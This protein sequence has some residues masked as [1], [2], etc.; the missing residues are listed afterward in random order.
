M[1]SWV[2]LY[3]SI[4]LLA[5]HFITPANA[6]TSNSGSHQQEILDGLAF[7]RNVDSLI[8]QALAHR[9]LKRGGTVLS[10]RSNAAAEFSR[11][12]DALLFEL[13]RHTSVNKIEQSDFYVALNRYISFKASY[14][15]LKER[16]R[17]AR[18]TLQDSG[19]S[20]LII[21]RM[22]EE[23]VMLSAR[24]ERVLFALKDTLGALE[25]T[26]KPNELIE[27][28]S[29]RAACG[30]AFGEANRL[31]SAFMPA[32]KVRILGN[33]QLSL[34]R[35]TY[36]TRA[37]ILTPNI[38]PSYLS[39]DEQLQTPESVDF[40]A[41]VDAPLSEE[42]LALARS[43]NYDYIRIYEYV[44]NNIRTEWYAG[45]MKGAVGALRQKS[46]NDVDQASLLIA[47][48]RA[49]GVTARYIHG[50]VELPIDRLQASLGVSDANQAIRAVTLAGIA[51]TPIVQ[52]G[53]ISALQMEH[54]W[55]SAYVPYI[56]YRG[57]VVD[58]SGKIWLSLV[59]ALKKLEVTNGSGIPEGMGFDSNAFLSGYLSEEQPE[60]PLDTLRAQTEAYLNVNEPDTQYNALLST[61][62]PLVESLGLLPNTMPVNVVAVTQESALLD[63]TRRQQVHF[64]IRSGTGT[65]DP[66][67]LDLT[68]PVSELASER[69]T[70]S[71]IPAT[72]DDH[73]TVNLFGGLDYVPAYLIKLRPQLKRNGRTIAVA[74]DSVDMAASHRLEITL[75]EGGNASYVEETLVAGGYH[76]IGLYAQDVAT[77]RDQDDP[78]DTEYQA[79]SL[80]DRIAWE[81]AQQWNTAEDELANL[82]GVSLIRPI[83]NLAIISSSYKVEEVLGRPHGMEWQGVT[84]DAALRVSEPVAYTAN[85]DIERDFL[86]LSGLEG[87]ALE[88]RVFEEQY[89]VD[90]LSADKALQLAHTSGA[91]VLT[92]TSTN[93]DV[94]LPTLDHPEAV[95]QDITNWISR[96]M[97]VEI[98]RMKTTYKNWLGSAWRVENPDTGEAGYYLTGG[99][100]GGS[101]ALAPPYWLL[102]WL[103]WALQAANTATANSDPLS[104][105]SINIISDT[106]QQEGE[107]GTELEKP[108]SVILHD[109]RGLP[110]VN[111]Q[112]VFSIAAGGG[113]FIYEVVEIVN[114]IEVVTEQRSSDP[115][116]VMTNELGIASIRLEPGQHTADNPVFLYRDSGDQYPTQ[117][118]H[119]LVDAM[120]QSH[121]G[122]LATPKSFEAIA[123]P[124]SRSKL[125]LTLS[126]RTGIL[127]PGNDTG[128]LKFEVQ[129]EFDNPISNEPITAQLTG[130]SP[131]SG[132][133]PGNLKGEAPTGSSGTSLNLYTTSYP[134][135]IIVTLGSDHVTY[136]LTVSAQGLNT[137]T[138]SYETVVYYGFH[139]SFSGYPG[140]D[141]ATGLGEF[142]SEPMEIGIEYLD[143]ETLT[144]T[145]AYAD[146][147][148]SF[149]LE[150]GVPST[151]GASTT[152]PVPTG[153]GTWEFYAKVGLNPTTYTVGVVINGYK[154][155]P[156][157][158]TGIDNLPPQHIL[159]I[160]A[161]D[162]SVISLDSG[163]TYPNVISVN[164][165][166]LSENAVNINYNVD[167]GFYESYVTHVLV[168]EDGELYYPIRTMSRTGAGSVT[169]PKGVRFDTSKSY[170]ARIVLNYG[171]ISEVES[172]DFPIQLRKKIFSAVD[173]NV[174][175]STEVDTINQRACHAGSK[176]DFTTS[177]PARI[178]LTFIRVD[179]PD[180]TTTLVDNE[181]YPEGIHAIDILPPDLT[182]GRYTF[183]L[184]G[185]SE[186]DGHTEIEEGNAISQFLTRNSL[187]VG[188]TIVKGVDLNEG[189]LAYG[190]TDLEIAG[191]GSQLEFRRTYNSN[192][193]V[194]PGRLGVGW[195]HNYAS[196]MIINDC[197]EAIV[198]GASGGGM[199]FVDDG[200]G[201]LMPLKGYHGTLIGNQDDHTFDFYSKDGT[202]YH[203]A[204]YGRVAWDLEFIEDTNGN[205]TKLG[206]D[207]SS[208]DVA[209]LTTVEDS[210]GRTLSF[211]YEN[212]VFPDILQ[213]EPQPI[214]IKVE[215]PDGIV[216]DFEFDTFGNLITAARGN[217]RLSQYEYSTNL[218]DPLT[219][220]HKLTAV[221]DPNSGRTVYEYNAADFNVTPTDTDIEPFQ[222]P[223][224]VVIGVTDTE[225]AHTGFAYDLPLPSTASAVTDSRN[226]DTAYTFNEY[227]SS[228]SIRDPVGTTTM[229]WAIDDILMTGK[230]DANGVQTDYTY[231]VDGNLLSETTG[232]V[233]R[234]YTYKAY[235]LKPWIKNRIGSQTNRNGHTTRFTY[236]GNGNL[237]EVRDP[238]GGVT[239]HA[240]STNGDRIRSHDANGNI[241]AY[242]YDAYGNLKSITDPLRNVTSHKWNARSLKT[243]TTDPLGGATRFEYD[244]LDNLIN[245]TDAMGGVRSF[246]Y[247]H[248]GNMLTET[249]EENRTTTW[250]YD[251]EN[252]VTQITNALNDT[253]TLTYDGNGNKLSE[254][255]WR[256]NLTSFGYDGANR[257]T[258]KT[259]PLAKLTRY[260]YDAVGNQLSETD[261]LNRVTRSTYNGLNQRV[262]LT[263]AL[264]GETKF[265]WDGEGNLLSQTDALNRVT[266]YTYDG[267]NRRTSQT[268]PLGRNTSWA[269]DAN[270]NKTAETDPND[271]NR[272][273]EYDGLNRVIASFDALNNQSVFEYDVNGNLTKK[274]N[275]RRQDTQHS[276]DALN[277]RTKTIDQADYETLYA[278]DGVGNLVQETQPN[279]N[280]I[281]ATYDDL[282]R[283]ISRSD[284]L[285]ALLSRSY[286]ADGNI[287]QEIDADGNVS[288][289]TYDELGRQTRA[290]LPEA[291]T[292]Q[293]G[294]DLLGNK[295]S[296]IDARNYTTG[297]TYDDLNRLITVTDPLTNETAYTYDAVGNKLSENDKRNNTTGFAY[298]DLNRLT[299]V[300]DPLT[301]TLAYTYDLNGNKLTEQD[302]RG[303]VTSYTYDAENRVTQVVKD[304]LR[305]AAYRYDEVGNKTY[306]TDAK[307]YT[308]AY[309]YDPRNLM[310]KESRPLAAI[311]NWTY[312]AM[313]DKLTERDPEGRTTTWTYD[314]RRRATSETDGEANTTAY[315][316][317]GNG[318]RLTTRRPNGNTWRYAYD[319]ADRLVSLTDPMS[320]AT[321]YTYDNNS[322]R[323][324]QT[325]ANNH[326][327][328]HTYDALNR[329][330]Q[331]SYANSASES[332]GYDENGNRT[333]YTDAMGQV[334]NYTY[335]ELNRETRRD[336]P[337]PVTPTGDDLQ[338]IATSYDAN[339]NPLTLSE[340]HA[341]GTRTTTNRYDSFDRLIETTDGFGKTLGYTY[342]ANGNRTSLSDPDGKISRYSFDALNRLS[343]VHNTTGISN[344]GYDRSSLLDN[345]SYPNGAVADYSYD[346]ARRVTQ[347]VNRLNGAVASQYDYTY[348]S[349][350]NRLTQQET[351]GGAVETTGYTY[352]NNDRLTRADYPDATLDYGYDS[353]YNRTSET[354]VE[355]VTSTTVANKTFSY[356][357]RNQV[358]SI[359]DSANTA[360]NTT[361]DYD[362]NGNQTVK[363]QNGST[364]NFLYDVR[365]RLVRVSQDTTT[366]GQFRYDH[367]GM[368]VQKEGA[369]GV[370]R[371]TYDD[372]SVLLQTDDA[373]TT[374]AKYDYGPDRL[375]SLEQAT[376]G[377]QF[378]HFD[379]LGSV[380]NL[381]KPDGSLQ[382]RYQY[383]AWGNERVTTGS[384]WNR[385]GFTGHEKDEETGLYYFKAR[386][387]DPQLGRFLSQDGYLGE[388][389]TPPSLHRYL[390]AY[391][392]PT[393][394][395][396]PTGYVPVLDEWGQF[397]TDTADEL[398]E[399]ASNT[400]SK[401]AAVGL[402]VM[403]GANFV[404]GGVVETVNFGLNIVGSDG[405]LG[406]GANDRATTE[407]HQAFDTINTIVE[408]PKGM[409]TVIATSVEETAKA[410]A[411]GETKAIA[412]TVAVGTSLMI[413]RPN[414]SVSSTA[415]GTANIVKNIAVGTGTVL[416]E[417]G[418]AVKNTLTKGMDN[419][420]TPS[421]PMFKQMGAVGD[422][423]KTFR[424]VQGQGVYVLRD[425]LSGEI[426]Y[427][428]RG[429][430]KA[431]GVVHQKSSDK[432]H[433]VQEILHDNTLNKPQAKYLEQ[434]L[435]DEFGGAKST[436]PATNL[437]NKIRSYSPRNPNASK[438]NVAGE[439]P[440]VAEKLWQETIKQLK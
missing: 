253:K 39:R 224:S 358:T 83:P 320:G 327:T 239:T 120:V 422:L 402:G 242:A 157:C 154:R 111:A 357:N 82:M 11:A 189:S 165:A 278:Y 305:I 21:Q 410:A 380:V 252:R 174:N 97:V 109:D 31:L 99:I 228:L 383:D 409:G 206:Y 213:T 112:V 346:D 349:N 411:R 421:N 416:K 261:A 438:Y 2:L 89:R 50:V 225:S 72:A 408:D 240:Y 381:S 324:T 434:K 55:V 257:L 71:Y 180:V 232:T 192:S 151:S 286:D 323:L 188:R 209:K 288:S 175:A 395:T 373:G 118:G 315:T 234:R 387:Y 95:K 182:P 9:N 279:G 25:A 250:V 334:F 176:L 134:A 54:T 121:S 51:F 150:D 415:T 139:H 268:E 423:N 28:A 140:G 354:A 47:L 13:Q 58:T 379:A 375:L 262:T 328:S 436:N 156:T 147:I 37:P 341:S 144:F 141:P 371:Y 313:G 207:P 68:L 137:I 108:L 275:A 311:T 153:P 197:G 45:A 287:V 303:T 317:D 119:N 321:R 63:D 281:D 57:A 312:D 40:S 417:T 190:E 390:Y 405:W 394:Y 19:S 101:T 398:I 233:T 420:L 294:Y 44:H 336:Y 353:A 199:R 85:P 126:E 292:I 368:R 123:Y 67:I 142:F 217:T 413:A 350:G 38:V 237:T 5:S 64:V 345:I 361:Y 211:F 33:A 382:A 256:G 27:Q 200:S 7:G 319:G 116:P 331:T 235:P 265:D 251:G 406:E 135:Q 196:Q 274:V 428:G 360:N 62:T 138:E 30:K 117:A 3:L 185:I 6:S 221:V 132:G 201:V 429:D 90:S 208:L 403:A 4:F 93:I 424:S 348:D 269:Y 388:G 202:R 290:D 419:L 272:R 440:D 43:L 392:N 384:S 158:T 75:L 10:P 80:L 369:Q 162:P 53:T 122:I 304:S 298:D 439:T 41:T 246:S 364:L 61:Q 356:N 102:D 167:P 168:L 169:L 377:E 399:Q 314:L 170:T 404:V 8:N 393:V 296:E 52:G 391:A 362:A 289:F 66:V 100:A 98:P 359:S 163:I 94:E 283:L 69:I 301:Q 339:S 171:M 16:N 107:V 363:T 214:L 263:D 15:L 216:L 26:P 219:L 187:P 300:T 372:G 335:D 181:L 146:S 293:S 340:T 79:A 433:L 60:L 110:V 127:L 77:V 308:T 81:Y 173:R 247:D 376:E 148:E 326:T 164:E 145:P 254:S 12:A 400:D 295:T 282:N 426:K 389:N 24:A 191:R 29:F 270:G 367:A 124:R 241:T 143:D 276:Y 227:G 23:I 249:D 342:D 74:Q 329:L 338:R 231:D 259:E 248:I 34:H 159:D 229:T 316:H 430:V 344:Y 306:E 115:V 42:I 194:V 114:D 177:Q 129:D 152:S 205:I 280:V 46:G 337:Q 65:T 407:L 166:G 183:E 96:G 230:R 437:L 343:T 243:Q 86:R 18:E 84:L 220:Q 397:H 396:D 48:Y 271:H 22:D 210:S 258:S 352:D 277:R 414:A 193:S 366:L 106:N 273:W 78:A 203:Y 322:N 330:T 309:I 70:L 431:R 136:T 1:K 401:L 284:R 218:E 285:G 355:K 91:E 35:T 302:K 238:E 130:S 125:A 160:T 370:V 56:N 347:V 307:G 325:D 245:R 310:T 17:T 204:N 267:L 198:I 113:Q 133:F 14:L 291:R 297:F 88:H 374:L 385:F 365:D 161:V 412:Q 223:Y 131:R 172:D 103:V 222:M 49:S 264:L 20:A 73:D 432:G 435:M 155:C 195:T 215:G 149:I 184:K 179:N 418:K 378:Y 59:P 128:Y 299:T 105:A 386:F 178:S 32:K 260:N 212:K 333:T 104:A 76:A 427:V 318:N 425:P 186:L 87:S 226:N 92:L 266:D 244:D 255:D 332:S 236:D 36:A 351:N